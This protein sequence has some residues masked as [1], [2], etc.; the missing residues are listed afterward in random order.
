MATVAPS[1]LNST[2]C[3]ATLS[4]ALAVMVVVPEMRRAVR[5]SGDRDGGQLVVHRDRARSTEVLVLPAASRATALSVWLPFE[6]VVVFSDSEYGLEVSAAP[7]FV[8]VHPELHALHADVVGRGRGE[9]R[10]CRPRGR[11]RRER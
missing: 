2:L 6:S 5:R 4:D 3:T 8:P 10:S 11:R 1:T 7:T 9:R